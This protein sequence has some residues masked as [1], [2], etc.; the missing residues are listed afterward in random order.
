M[1]L[2]LQ[3]AV[4][5]TNQAVGTAVCLACRATGVQNLRLMFECPTCFRLGIVPACDQC[6]PPTPALPH[7]VVEPDEEVLALWDE[8]GEID[9]ESST[10]ASGTALDSGFEFILDDDSAFGD[11]DESGFTIE[12]E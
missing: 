3:C 5:G 2:V 12:F 8:E 7:E 6:Q 10:P 1:K 4:C 11:E 9:L